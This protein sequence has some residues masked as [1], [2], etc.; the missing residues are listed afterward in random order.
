MVTLRVSA[1]VPTKN[2]PDDLYRAIASIKDQTRLPDELIIIDQSP[3]R[4]SVDAIRSLVATERHIILTYIHDTRISGLV[5]AKRVGARACASDIVCFLEDDV[6]LERDY[7]AE[8]ERGFVES[9]EMLGCSGVITNFPRSSPVFALA[10]VLFF[11]GIFHDPRPGIFHTASR[12]DRLI[13]CDMLSG[14]L[15]AWRRTVFESVD[16]DTSNGFF[17]MEDVEFSTRVVKQFGHRLYVNPRARL[18][19]RSSPVNRDVL[20]V[21]QRRKLTEAAVYFKKRRQWPGARRGLML[22]MAWWWGEAVMQTLKTRSINPLR[23][24]CRGVVDGY[25][26]QLASPVDEHGIGPPAV[27]PPVDALN[28]AREK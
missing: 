28:V 2:R 3:G 7:L 12:H 8:I 6:I 5:E 18:E 14:G 4:E 26:R 9:T 20:G 24:Y 13:P 21:R 10:H 19:H 25:R 27:R 15:S 23:E 1:V 17:M 11:R 22:A 16:I